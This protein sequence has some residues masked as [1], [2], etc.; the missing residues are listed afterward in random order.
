IS[1]YLCPTPPT[2]SLFLRNVVDDTRLKNYNSK[3]PIVDV[4]GPIVDVYVSLD[5]Y[6][7]Y[8]RGFGIFSYPFSLSL[9]VWP[10]LRGKHSA[11]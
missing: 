3:S 8:T 4:Y 5:F 11:T 6:T 7:C 9:P 1:L 2:P 10:D